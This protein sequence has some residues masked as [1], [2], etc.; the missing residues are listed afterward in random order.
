MNLI[1]NLMQYEYN[2]CENTY[3]CFKNS[4]SILLHAYMMKFLFHLIYTL[5]LHD[6]I[7]TCFV[8]NM[9]RYDGHNMKFNPLL[10]EFFLGY[11]EV[12]LTFNTLTAHDEHHSI[13]NPYF[14]C[15]F[16]HYWILVC[17]IA[18]R[19]YLNNMFTTYS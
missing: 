9:M 17:N 19:S 10:M 8:L 4:N 14:A 3:N 18:S 11:V 1:F 7:S 2:F 15:V 13:I 16:L 12:S 6:V 5:K